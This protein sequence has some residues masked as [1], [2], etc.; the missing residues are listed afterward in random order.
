L[1]QAADYVGSNARRDAY[2]IPPEVLDDLSNRCGR[3]RAMTA[4]TPIKPWYRPPGTTLW[5][6]AVFWFARRS[7]RKGS[8]DIGRLS[9]I[10]FARWGIVRRIPDLGQPRERLRR[11]MFMFESNYN[12]TF[13]DY[14]D[15]FAHILTR[16]MTL[17]WGSSYGFPKPIPVSRFMDYIHANEF[18]ASHYY[19]AYPTE[20]ATM[21]VSALAFEGP[22]EAFRR[23]APSL[24]PEE[25]ANAYKRFLTDEQDKL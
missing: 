12:G 8:G 18:V 3:T 4:F 16:G 7:L 19:S 15:A 9:F 13:G 20:T 23:A 17:F 24:T 6:R 5:V 25:F 21:I 1:D 22:H 10:H 14:I 11:P 2:V